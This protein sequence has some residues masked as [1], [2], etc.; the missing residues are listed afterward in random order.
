MPANA[1]DTSGQSVHDGQDLIPD[2]TEK[3]G[4][5][6][7]LEFLT[8]LSH[9]LRTPL[10]GLLGHADLLL[11]DPLLNPHQRRH[12]ESIQS[13]GSALLTV[14]NQV[15]NFAIS[16]AHDIVVDR[17][18]FDLRGLLQSLVIGVR[19]QAES[20]G[21]LFE[22]HA[23]ARL[24]RVVVG[25]ADRLRQVL[26]NLFENALN[27]TSRGHIRAVID[28]DEAGPGSVRLRFSLSDAGIG[29]APSR[30]S[31]LFDDGS[32]TDPEIRS[33]FGGTGLALKVAKKL[34][35]A[36]DGVLRVE[37]VPHF[38]STVSF[39]LTMPVAS[40][41]FDHAKGNRI[42]KAGSSARILLVEDDE[43]SQD[44]VRS[45]L[46]AEGHEVD[47]ATDGSFAV[48]AV[49][50]NVYD[51]VL[52]D[53]QMPVL[54][55]VSATKLIRSLSGPECD[56]PVIAM[57]ASILPDQVRSFKAAGMNDHVGKPFQREELLAVVDRWAFDSINQ[58]IRSLSG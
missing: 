19:R 8:S 9:A 58:V 26:L 50:S 44:V 56:V 57:T 2:G 13:A 38:G 47:V 35:E 40:E 43:I 36:M 51:L 30:L 20:K 45:I 32:G 14:A 6:V 53:V 34:I 18:P 54:D 22:L 23:D 48:L 46:E 5:R 27:V 52:M 42:T 41:T 10:N 11:D 15:V 3:A 17:Q 1:R 49:Q 12:A 25:D 21:I 55:G 39:V 24:P 33:E 29:I 16:N 4:D 28:A 31:A 37:S 7:T